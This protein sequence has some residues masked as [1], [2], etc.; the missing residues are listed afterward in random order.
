MAVS[1]A[2]VPTPA[3]S[4]QAPTNLH[5]DHAFSL[6]R[7]LGL[8]PEGSALW[9]RHLLQ[10]GDWQYSRELTQLELEIGRQLASERSDWR[11][12]ERLANDFGAKSGRAARV[13]RHSSV[14]TALQLTGRDRKAIGAFLQQQAHR[15]KTP[16]PL[17]PALEQNVATGAVGL[18]RS[19][20]LSAAGTELLIQGSRASSAKRSAGSEAEEAI[21]RQL[22]RQ[23]P[24]RIVLNGLVAKWAAD[25]ARLARLQQLNL[26]EVAKRLSPSDRQLLGRVLGNS[27]SQELAG[28]KP[29][30]EIVP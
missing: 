10:A 16:T 7:L 9:A 21:G 5:A 18:H 25:Q 6:G 28:S 26:I 17:S 12:L 15:Q 4:V 14:N 23:E 11:L 2:F 27:V 29:V 22:S 13:R 8:T 24:D 19:M 20:G 3:A 30:L 1:L